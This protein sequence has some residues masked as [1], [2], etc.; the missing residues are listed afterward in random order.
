[1]TRRA[2]D[3][4]LL[5]LV[6]EYLAADRKWREI[7]RAEADMPRRLQFAVERRARAQCTDAGRQALAG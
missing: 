2:S 3:A 5:R 1:M 7:N 6:D 4:A